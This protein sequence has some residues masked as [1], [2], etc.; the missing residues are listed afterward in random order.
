M[1][2]AS[3]FQYRAMFVKPRCEVPS[4]YQAVSDVIHCHVVRI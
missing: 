1:K 2:T 4:V 3:H